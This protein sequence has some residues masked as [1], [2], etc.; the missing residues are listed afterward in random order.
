[1]E[2]NTIAH[3]GGTKGKRAYVERNFKDEY[4]IIFLSNYDAIPFEKLV[5]DLQKIMRGE[6]VKM[7]KKVSRKAI[8][9][10]PNILESY[11]GTYDLVE[12]G[13][14]VISFKLENGKL[15]AY[16]N[17]SNN[18]TIYAESPTVFFAEATSEESIEF[19]T[20]ANGEVY[21]LIDFQGVRWKGIKI[22]SP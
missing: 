12:A 17:G 4:Q 10:N 14:I 8:D 1:M 5:T 19:V 7:P 15:N 20:E 22:E 18:G 13:H 11:Q 3:A 6:K 2:D 16:Q 9:L 21:V